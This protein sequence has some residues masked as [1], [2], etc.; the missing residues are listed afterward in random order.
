MNDS[1]A[2]VL[3]L[4]TR[5]RRWST[6]PRS[7]PRVCGRA[8]WT[9]GAGAGVRQQLDRGGTHRPGHRCGAVFYFDLAG[10]PLVVVRG[11][12]GNCGRFITFAVIM[13]LL[14]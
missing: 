10:E 12:I 14:S 11:L 4:M 1:L 13:L 9:T 3:A 7:R 5:K 8:Y 2:D 6:L